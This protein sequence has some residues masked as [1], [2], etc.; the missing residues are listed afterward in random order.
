MGASPRPE[1]T[2]HEIVL[3]SLGGCL[4]TKILEI[5]LRGA[6][7]VASKAQA[8][9]ATCLAEPRN[10][11]SVLDRSWCAR[12]IAPLLSCKAANPF[13]SL[14]EAGNPSWAQSLLAPLMRLREGTDNLFLK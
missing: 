4:R 10:T 1:A 2:T 3:S 11:P 8:S 13:H 5:L 14:I 7:S 12:R 6:D 9:S